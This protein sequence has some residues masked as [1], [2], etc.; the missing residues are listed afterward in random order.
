MKNIVILTIIMF[1]LGF[2]THP[3][4][5]AMLEKP[6]ADRV[7]SNWLSYIVNG[8]GDWAGSLS[9]SIS[10]SIPIEVEGITVAYAYNIEPDGYII[11]S[12]PEELAPIKAYSPH[13]KYDPNRPTGLPAILYED[14]TNK[15]DIISNNEEIS[16][17]DEVS[18]ANEN[19]KRLRSLLLLPKEEYVAYLAGKSD[20]K[21]ETVGPLIATEWHQGAPYN[22][23]CPI[24]D[25]GRTAVWCVST[26]LSQ[27]MWYHQWPPAGFGGINYYWNG[28]GSCGGSSPGLMLSANFFDKYEWGDLSTP[29]VAE[30]CEEVGKAYSVDYGVCYSFGSPNNVLTLLPNNFAYSS[31]VVR[32]NRNSYNA[33]TWFAV[34]QNEINANRPIQYYIYDHAIVCDGWATDVG[35]NYYHMNYGWGGGA[36]GW[37]AID[38]LYCNWAGCNYTNEY[39]FINIVP[40]KSIMFYAD[41]I[42]GQAP[43][44][45]QFTGSSDSPVEEWDWDFGDGNSADI[46]NPTHT[47]ADP[48]VYNVGVTIRWGEESEKS[49]TRV[50]Y[51]YALADSIY[52][53]VNEY[54]IEAGDQVEVIVNAS[55]LIRLTDVDLHIDY[56]GSLDLYFDSCS[57]AGCRTSTFQAIDL[58]ENDVTNKKL[59]VSLIAWESG[60]SVQPWLSEGDGSLIKLY[61]SSNALANPGESTT[62]RLD[63]YDSQSTVFFGSINGQAHDYLPRAINSTIRTEAVCGDA[64]AD[65]TVNILDVTFL[66]AY[67]YKNGSSPVS[68]WCANPNGDATIN[69]LDVTYLISYLYKQGPV[70]HCQ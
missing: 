1:L 65:E 50:S 21:A 8:R 64:N 22:N 5:A 24:G 62:I 60:Y 7:C 15:L 25:G 46:Q 38:N 14:Y 13:G 34:I 59:S 44:E 41:T 3:S 39:M 66:I 28:D 12:L 43:L 2:A 58:I 69:I 33:A 9:P 16:Y 47:Y 19:Q 61:F 6:D 53:D 45:I 4:F 42:V 35:V 23:Y 20:D 57:I 37:Y 26:A 30:I 67:L 11:V 63:G 31:D 56:S 54:V 55:N 32:R 36:N 10:L 17:D 52:T 18:L 49:K 29:N 27:I 68:E 48:G 51:I 40:D 70:P